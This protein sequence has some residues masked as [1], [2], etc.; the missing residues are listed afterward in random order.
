MREALKTLYGARAEFSGTFARMGTKSRFGHMSQTVLLRDIRDR[1]NQIVADHLWF[2]LTKGFADLNA[3]P[4]EVVHF[5]ARVAVYTKGYF[6]YRD[7]VDA[8]P[9]TDYKLKNPTQWRKQEHTKPLPLFA[10]SHV[11]KDAA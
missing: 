11:P 10:E 2:S 4:G 8:P 5:R 3:Q 6:G 1:R 9:S 7:D